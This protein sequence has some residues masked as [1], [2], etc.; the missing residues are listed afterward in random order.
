MI[1]GGL[2]CL[3]LAG[4]PALDLP[5]L[6]ARAQAAAGDVSRLQQV[7]AKARRG[8]AISLVTIGGSITEG[9]AAS[10]VEYRWANRLA[11]W[12]GETFPQTE[13]R[14]HNAGIGAT[15]S[16]L[17]AHRCARDVLPHQPDLVVI[18]FSVNDPNSELAA[19]T[20]EGL[21]R[22]I[23]SQP[24]QPAVMLLHTMHRDGGN[25]Q[26]Q[27][28]RVGDHYGL[29]RV[30]FRD[31]VWPEIAAGRL[32]WEAV[33]ADLVH[34]NDLGHAL[35]A[36][37]LADALAAVLADLPP[38]DRLRAPAPLP[39]PLLSDTFEHGRLLTADLATVVESA[40]FAPTVT[41]RLGPGWAATEPGSRLVIEASGSAFM[42]VFQRIKGD[43][44]RVAVRI[45]EADP[46]ICEAWF[47]ADWGGYSA[48][49]LLAR[50]LPPGKH[51]IELELLPE[52][53]PGSGGTRF[54][55]HAL[56][57]AGVAA[58]L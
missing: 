50:D 18:E 5:A 48:V 8:E 45:D 16:D 20:L 56:L 58:G 49:E 14:F 57:A 9:A 22:Q 3:M 55:V 41:S 1:L 10:R 2:T 46:V 39:P 44:G 25:A 52:H 24:Q 17:G 32:A 6:S 7:L 15:G 43:M 11:A 42:L 23:L 36:R 37:F 53:H 30:S 21:V 34:P 27:H 38:D 35:C 31:A 19:E 40:G 29:P 47:D 12:L 33:E 51:R 28:G 13:I 54:E 26:E 4:E